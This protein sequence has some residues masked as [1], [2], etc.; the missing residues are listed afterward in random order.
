[1]DDRTAELFD[2][3]LAVQA[4]AAPPPCAQGPYRDFDFWVGEWDVKDAAGKPAGVNA[5]TNEQGGCVIVERWK[6]AQ[7]GTGQSLNYY[8]PAAKT[9]K[10]LWVGLGILLHMEGGMSE[11]SM[12]LEGPL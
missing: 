8:D 3:A 4:N 9:W 10:Q 12:R 1:M 7:G 2:A 11:G 6:G 5:I